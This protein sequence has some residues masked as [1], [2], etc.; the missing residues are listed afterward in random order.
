MYIC[1]LVTLHL[2]ICV[3]VKLLVSFF[4]AICNYAS[5]LLGL[6]MN[7]RRFFQP[8]SQV[9]TPARSSDTATTESLASLQN[10]TSLFVEDSDDDACQVVEERPFAA[11]KDAPK[12]TQT[13]SNVSDSATIGLEL[14]ESQFLAVVGSA[15]SRAINYLY[16]KHFNQ[17]NYLKLATNEYFNGI[18]YDDDDQ[19]GPPATQPPK[20]P[21]SEQNAIDHNDHIA[22]LY[23]RLRTQARH[24]R[25]EKEAAL[26]SKFIGTLDIQA[27][28]TRPTMRPL[29]FKQKLEL[30]RLIP[31]S[32]TKSKAETNKKFGDTAVI[33]ISTKGDN[34]REIGRLPE[35][36]T[37]VLAPLLDLEIALFDVTVLM[38]TGKRLSIGDSFYVQIDC[39]LKNTAFHDYN[40]TSSSTAA[41]EILHD[42]KRQKKQQTK[43]GFN[44]STETDTEAILKLRQMSLSRLFERLHIKPFSGNKSK[45][46]TEDDNRVVIDDE[47]S[48]A[49]PEV[50]DDEAVKEELTP[51]EQSAD[52]LNLDQ[53]KQ[54]YLQN[55]QTE[56]LESLPD[57][58][59]PPEENFKLTLKP[60]QRHGLSWMLAREK[61]FDILED[62]SSDDGSNMLSTQARRTIKDKDQGMMNPLWNVFEWP[63]DTSFE[64]GLSTDNDNSQSGDKHFYA[65]MYNG[66][67]SLE[68]PILKTLVRGGILADEMGL[69]KTISTLAL[70]TSAP[71]DLDDMIS[72]R[73]PYASRTTLIVVPT[74]L[75]AQ[76]KSEFDTANN[77]PN[78]KCVVY[79][80]DLVQSNLATLLCKNSDK[81]VPIVL[82]TTYGTIQNEYARLNKMRDMNGN[83]PK[84]GIYSVKFFRVVLDE[85]HNIRNRSNKTSKAIYEVSLRRNWVLTG[86][87]VINRLDDIYSL[88][89]F[90]KLE[91]WCNFSYWKTF[92]TLPFEQ[93]KF[94][95]TLDVVKS[96]LEPILL[97]RT[98]NMK[99]KDGQPLVQLPSKEIVVE[100]IEFS[101]KELEL[102]NTFKIRASKT[103]DD[104]LKSGQLLKRYTQILTHILR[105][106]QICCHT[107]LVGLKSELDDDL[108][109]NNQG[110]GTDPMDVVANTEGF[111]NPTAMHQ[112]MY[113][114]YEKVN[115]EESECSICTQAPILLG[116]M[117]LTECGHLYCF[118]C[119]IEHIEFQQVKEQEPFCPNCR[120]VISK[121]RLF[122]LR[123]RDTTKKDI[124]FYTK[125]DLE[126]PSSNYKFQ[127]YL[128]NP[129]RMSSKI[130][131]LLKHLNELKS[132]H[133]GEKVVVFS[134]FS[135]Y[136]DII[137]NELSLDDSGF[138]VL[139]FDGR[140][141]MQQ[142]E[143]S[144]A[145]FNTIKTDK[146]V[147]LLLSLKAGGVGLNLTV[148]N[149]VF[150]MDPWWSPSI[151]DQAV[152]RIHRIGQVKDVK[153]VRFI[154]KNSIEIKMLKIQERKRKMGEAVEVEEEERRKHRIE[155]IKMLFE[156]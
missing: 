54:F 88:V 93:K 8:Q 38:D 114:L 67:L 152:D 29:Q 75:L 120:T 37:R 74:S 143:T 106:R 68:K 25:E 117:V 40:A 45:E 42:V 119:I 53:L 100:E 30:K 144:L 156:E 76:W 140:L 46:A 124:R 150:M 49:M 62:L 147:V 136:L 155:E 91:P 27:W 3:L 9:M 83:M 81:N 142:R 1:I 6:P 22:D 132:S 154:I 71:Y 103:F 15:S 109:E 121:Y 99:Q 36:I 148:S 59:S 65:N 97:R 111:E 113:S 7:K 57:N 130:D 33:R 41:E 98:K 50:V 131:A 39:F 92:V 122:K 48:I 35:D 43:V 104:G 21:H 118:S 110:D 56:F 79:Y 101:D 112:V 47:D 135:S 11:P 139:K 146:V 63:K 78:H 55:Q 96:I 32:F 133:P 13:H 87:P 108:K 153:V 70:V 105:L 2:V 4:A 60:Y 84:M 34:A 149:R 85:G 82:I 44:F 23:E 89:K 19:S 10:N 128:Y 58:T 5:T 18:D 134:Q 20:R 116:D 137:H 12:L 28:A 138:H 126:D 77:N 52:L 24:Q 31:K 107:D 94:G 14:F 69:G 17:P 73:L 127:L 102:Y 64:Q 90:L 95:H 51:E 86:T 145:N 141:N 26:W 72:D 129:D 16:K 66:E 125:G 61:E 123:S 115:L 80:G 151:E